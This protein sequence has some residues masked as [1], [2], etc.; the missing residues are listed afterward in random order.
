MTPITAQV[1]ATAAGAL[2]LTAVLLLWR[3]SISGGVALLGLQGLALAGLAVATTPDGE[4]ELYALAALLA[5]GKGVVIPFL[6]LRTAAT[7]GDA[8]QARAMVNPTVGMLLAAA[9]TTIAFLVARPLVT[10]STR[11]TAAA[12]PVGLA[13][14]LIGFL[15][16][17]SR[18]HALSQIVGFV[19]VDN[20]IGATA[21]LSTGGLPAIIELGV[22][23]DVVLVVLV[24]L[25]LTRR[26]RDSFTS[27]DVHELRE[28]RD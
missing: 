13:V 10:A 22:L 28:L 5:L 18:T 17:T 9:F 2:L 3:R 16:L 7:V 21:L 27:I 8:G 6:V 11:P 19:M 4:L 24:L 12:I 15:V 25:V 1:L 14:V 26:I 23:F 20:G